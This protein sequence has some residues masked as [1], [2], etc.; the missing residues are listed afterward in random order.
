MK[1]KSKPKRLHDTFYLKE[2]GIK[3]QKKVLNI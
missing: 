1:I 3:I 2:T